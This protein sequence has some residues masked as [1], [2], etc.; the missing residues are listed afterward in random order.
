[1]NDRPS[2]Y[3]THIKS[4]TFTVELL[5]PRLALSATPDIAAESVTVDTG[6]L[7]ALLP[8]IE[9]SHF[10][11][12][13]SFANEQGQ[14]YRQKFIDWA[15]DYISFITNSGVSVAYINIGD[16]SIDTKNYYAYLDPAN[17]PNGVP[18]IVTEFLDKLPAGV[19]AGAISYLD[20]SDAWKVYD[21]QNF[22]GN[23]LTTDG[24]Q[25]SPPKNNLYQSFQLINWINHEQLQAG[26][27]KF[28]THYQADGE[29]AGAFET[30]TYYGF[31]GQVEGPYDQSH[32]QS[33]PG[34]NWSWSS[35]PSP[36]GTNNGWPVAG[37]GYTK[38]LWNHFMPGVDAASAAVANGSHP[39]TG[40]NVPDVVFS[41]TEAI[42]PDTWTGGQTAPYRFGIIKYAQTSW[43]K[44]SPGPMKAYTE[45]YWFGENHYMPGPGSAIAPDSTATINFVATPVLDPP[46]TA[47]NFAT[48]PTVTF[49]QPVDAQGQPIGTPAM[50]HAVMGTGSIDKT[51]LENGD[52]I[53]AFFGGN[54]VGQ[55]FGTGA[56][57]TDGGN[58]YH[59]GDIVWFTPPGAGG[60][61]AKGTINTSSK[62]NPAPIDSVIITDPGEGYQNE[63]TVQRITKADGTTT[64]TGSG[65][66][67]HALVLAED[68]YPQAIFPDPP[69]GGRKAKGY[70]TVSPQSY[71]PGAITGL[72]ITD[73]GAGYPLNPNSATPTTAGDPFGG[74]GGLEIQFHGVTPPSPYNTGIS[75][76]PP[77][78][79][80]FYAPVNAS[81]NQVAQI[82][83][84]VL[85]DHYDTET[86]K[87]YYTLSGDPSHT[88]HYLKGGVDGNGINPD[89]NAAYV[90]A[91][92]RSGGFPVDPAGRSSVN[93][94][95]SGFGYSAGTVLQSGGSGYDKN[96]D[97]PVTFPTP[98]GGG[99]PAEGLLVVN[100][101][102]A[103]TGVVITSPGAGYTT[104]DD[105]HL[106]TLPKPDGGTAATAKV[107]LSNF[108]SVTLTPS[109]Q[110]NAFTPA[111]PYAITGPTDP[112]HP[113]GSNPSN[114]YIVTG[115]GFSYPG[116][117]YS[118]A[119]EFTFAFSPPANV[120]GH[121]QPEARALPAYASKFSAASLP[122]LDE[123]KNL[124][125]DAIHG[126]ANTYNWQ[127][128][129][130]YGPGQVASIKQLVGGSGYTTSDPPTVTFSPPPAGGKQATGRSVVKN[131]TVSE[132][133]IEDPG[134]GYD[135]TQLPEVTIGSP[136]NSGTQATAGVVLGDVNI[137][138]KAAFQTVYAH[139]ADHPE[140]LAAMFNDPLYQDVSLPKLS[141]KFYWPIDWSSFGSPT[142]TDGTKTPQQAIATFSIESLNRSNVN[143]DHPTVPVATVLDAKYQ[144]P[145]SLLEP[146]TYGGTFAGLSSLS[147]T[148]FVSFLNEAATIISTEAK[149]GGAA[150][151]PHDVT[152][153]IYDA[154]FL[155]LEWLTAKNANRWTANN[156][157]PVFTSPRHGTVD[158]GSSLN[159]VVYQA[160]TSDAGNT[161]AERQV[162]YS[163]KPDVGDY[164][165]VSID[166]HTGAVQILEP[167]NHA[168]KSEYQF[169]VVA[170]DG[171]DVPLSSEQPV[172]VTVR[173]SR[174]TR[175]QLR[176]VTTIK[177]GGEIGPSPILFSR[178][179]LS[180]AA[181]SDSPE[182]SFVVTAVAS[183]RVEKWDGSRWLDV[184]TAPASSNPR[185]L[186]ALLRQRQVTEG[187]QIRWVPPEDGAASVTAFRI[188]GFDGIAGSP[189]DSMITVNAGLPDA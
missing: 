64:S 95:N 40:T 2:R 45:N 149:N 16:Y 124:P 189:G 30:D 63:P 33:A 106:F 61:Q 186:L 51:A 12:D 20:A 148:N 183:G 73:Y 150:M 56:W 89:Y 91:L 98:S 87:P 43:L 78:A 147:Y 178:G 162:S 188:R 77:S 171:G 22:A 159:S 27:T 24:K 168:I 164:S 42:D 182:L 93:I 176:R 83:I 111:R 121:S 7:P 75:V 62:Y 130:G 17:D 138:S 90:P 100:S 165:Q 127:I 23:H 6:R 8:K 181:L 69:S 96:L 82:V 116:V 31:G 137:L 117:G 187:D 136:T 166:S 125:T 155:P 113:N 36:N 112:K 141:E 169:T 5:E 132:I 49:N 59:Q 46:T 55:G 129:N 72:V 48:T 47:N 97:Y 38:W 70:V 71:R 140:L 1:M 79:P 52:A 131:G 135:P 108:P 53:K 13:I 110:A 160:T 145:D 44:Y 154:A 123:V 80:S 142:A 84:T 173:S 9:V 158:E 92:N 126:G 179:D 4:S 54:G 103:V 119:T 68:G 101:D 81:E 14:P 122:T 102:G 143:P 139:Y 65:A 3:S 57:V 185:E 104:A 21:Q 133:I 105:D 174:I 50:G 10:G 118:P 134:Y 156:A 76:T 86:N 170:S 34:P 32:N 167:A 146:N 85:G 184:S 28:I 60:R 153:Q 120:P 41:D 157:A 66:V 19:E 114:G 11:Q 26:G 177:I 25:G 175:P 67:I 109:S 18:W 115:I 107:Y 15:E 37:Y 29:G 172:T 35:T 94:I 152:F 161:A 128:S 144:N 58:G 180:A 39:L 99:T 88:K 74:P 151:S 163:I